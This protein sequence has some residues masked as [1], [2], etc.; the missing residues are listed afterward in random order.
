MFVDD[1]VKILQEHLM[2]YRL[3]LL[4]VFVTSG[5]AQINW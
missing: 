4:P 3:Q 5:H 1:P 2:L